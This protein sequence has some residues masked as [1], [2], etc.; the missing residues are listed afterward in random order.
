MATLKEMLNS[1]YLDEKVPLKGKVALRGWMQR[2]YQLQAVIDNAF[3]N[4]EFE[5]CFDLL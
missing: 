5:C 1:F 2:M 4:L 3:N